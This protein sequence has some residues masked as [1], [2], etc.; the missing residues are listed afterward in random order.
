MTRH[1][2]AVAL[3]RFLFVIPEATQVDVDKRY[4]LVEQNYVDN[5]AI[6]I[7]YVTLKEGPV[8]LFIYGFPNP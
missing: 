8:L 5:A 6:K 4:N 2:L 3:H 7:H 1:I